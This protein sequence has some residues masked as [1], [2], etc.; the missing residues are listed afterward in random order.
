MEYFPT[1]TMKE[2][3]LDTQD[4][5]YPNGLDS[6]LIGPVYYVN[7]VIDDQNSI[8]ILP[9]PKYLAGISTHTKPN[10]SAVFI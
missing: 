6:L 9:Q 4:I 2:R 8:F 1:V 7:L 10:D 3:K 5:I